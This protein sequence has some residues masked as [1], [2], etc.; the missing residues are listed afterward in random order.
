MLTSGKE[1]RLL[2]ESH[3]ILLHVVCGGTGTKYESKT[4]RSP[5]GVEL[6]DFERT[7]EVAAL[8]REGIFCDFLVEARGGF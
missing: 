6:W 3:R 8:G 5:V 4:G 2:V 1:R 7:K